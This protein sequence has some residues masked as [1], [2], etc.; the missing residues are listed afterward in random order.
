MRS[1]LLINLALPLLGS[2]ALYSQTKPNVLFIMTDQQSYNMMICMGNKWL[3][4]PNMDKIAGMG[5]RFDK[6][7]CVNPVCMPSRFSLLTGHY[8][9]EV[10]VKENTTAYDIPKVEKII[11]TDALGIIFRKAGYE[12]S[13]SGKTHLFGTKNVSEYGFNIN[14]TDPYDRPAI[15]AEQVLAET[16]KAKQDKPF[17][18]F[19]SFMNPHDICYKAGADKRYPDNLPAS[20]A[21]ETVRLLALQKSLSTADYRKQIPPRATNFAPIN[22]EN[23]DMVSMDIGSRN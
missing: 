20:N 14:N 9:S 5:Y 17:F 12:T 15:Y 10:G 16:G 22:D 19:L 23:P 3:S 6:T 2:T 4:T 21:R 18:L 1:K 13:Y 11:A 7:Y 8:A